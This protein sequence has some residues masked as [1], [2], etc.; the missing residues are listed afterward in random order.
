VAAGDAGGSVVVAVVGAW[1]LLGADAAETD[2]C[3]FVALAC[4]LALVV[5]WGSLDV[6]GV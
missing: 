4:R 3:R 2:H 1:R 5:Q 6:G